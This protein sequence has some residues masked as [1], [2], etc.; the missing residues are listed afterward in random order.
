M[1]SIENG[2]DQDQIW[3]L[4][5][6]NLL[7]SLS[8][9]PP[10]T[11]HLMIL[12]MVPG[13]EPPLSPPSIPDPSAHQDRADVRWVWVGVHGIHLPLDLHYRPT[14]ILYTLN[15]GCEEGGEVKFPE[16]SSM[17][18]VFPVNSICGF[19]LIFDPAARSRTTLSFLALALA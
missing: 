12:V 14:T 13:D 3:F 5:S 18:F 1:P 8:G 4:G 16:C 7:A 10:I 19:S 15:H 11:Y 17:F 2:S 9:W 6:D